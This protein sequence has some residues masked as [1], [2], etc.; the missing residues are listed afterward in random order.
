MKLSGDPGT[1]LAQIERDYPG[2]MVA[3]EQADK[4]TRGQ[5]QKQR[6]YPY[7][8]AALYAL[9]SRYNSESCNMLEIG[10]Y[11]G[12]T[13]FVTA[14]AAP[15]ATLT[16]LNPVP[17]EYDIARQYL[18]QWPRVRPFCVHS[19]DYLES[20]AG[21]ELDFI[22]V[23]G[24]H[25]RVRNDLPWFN[26]LSPGGLIVFHDYSPNGSGRA[27]PPVWRALQWLSE[28]LE[29]AP[30]VEI[31]DDQNVGMVGWYKKPTDK[32]VLP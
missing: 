20:Y 22:F 6:V 8:A 28:Y 14:S 30:D 27:C 32:K 2:V 1:I 25:K 15:L 17:W 19:W 26:W 18:K 4:M 12:Y 7:Q 23:D 9:A 5:S 24:D 29:R 16:T 21:P 13:A 3:I 31:I 11:Y 10:T